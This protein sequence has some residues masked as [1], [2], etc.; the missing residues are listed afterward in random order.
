[1]GV[2]VWGLLEDR[3]IEL[4]VQPAGEDRGFRIEGLPEG[5]MRTTTDRVRAA[6]VNSGLVLEAPSVVIRLEPAVRSGRT[7]DLDLGLALVALAAT[8]V[9]GSGLRWILGTGRLGL[10]GTV[11]ADGIAVGPTLRE[12]ANRL[13]QTPLLASE[14]MFEK[15]D[16]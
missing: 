2:R 15:K 10:D 8:G 7:G 3:L 6:L 14:R 9:V 13:C 16:R 5:R 4:R 1:M 12:V 11:H